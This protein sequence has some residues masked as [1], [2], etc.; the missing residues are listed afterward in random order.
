ML[1]LDYVITAKL[2]LLELHVPEL[3]YVI[4]ANLSLWELH[5]LAFVYF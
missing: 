1:E 4:T 5:E 2:T 3:D